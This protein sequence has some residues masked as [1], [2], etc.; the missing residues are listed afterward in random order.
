MTDHVGMPRRIGASIPQTGVRLSEHRKKLAIVWF[1][2][3]LFVVL[4]ATVTMLCGLLAYSVFTEYTN[5]LG[6]SAIVSPTT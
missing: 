5:A 4:I 1:G 3:A 2:Y 6:T